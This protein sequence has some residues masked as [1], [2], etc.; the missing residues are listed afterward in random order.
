[1]KNP[2]CPYK[3]IFGRPSEGVH[4]YRL[5]GLAIFDVSATIVGALLFAWF[6]KWNVL[7]TLIGFFLSGIIAHRL[8]CVRTEIDK[9]LFVG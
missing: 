6:F 7:I 3:Y 5:F 9:I 2:L 1:M 8:F 4:S